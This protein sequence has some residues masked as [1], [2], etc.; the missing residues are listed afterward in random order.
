MGEAT[1]LVERIRLGKTYRLDDRLDLISN[2]AQL[3]GAP[4]PECWVNDHTQ[5]PVARPT[6]REASQDSPDPTGASSSRDDDGASSSAYSTRFYPRDAFTP[7]HGRKRYRDESPKLQTREF[8]KIL[9]RDRSRHPDRDAYKNLLPAPIFEGLRAVASRLDPNLGVQNGPQGTCPQEPSVQ[10]PPQEDDEA[11][12]DGLGDERSNMGLD[13]D[14]IPPPPNVQ[15]ADL[16]K[17]AGCLQGSHT[18]CTVCN[19]AVAKQTILCP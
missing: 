4:R 1:T 8:I 16:L 17:E 15:R 14:F 2:T 3:F 10:D 7:Q 5:V 13:E 12:S 9:K 6:K 18:R 11:M 19:S